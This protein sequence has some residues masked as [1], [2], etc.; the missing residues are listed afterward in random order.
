MDLLV[1]VRTPT[2]LPKVLPKSVDFLSIE[3]DCF[4]DLGL[5]LLPFEGFSNITF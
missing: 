5:L 2:L 1:W 4:L 3:F